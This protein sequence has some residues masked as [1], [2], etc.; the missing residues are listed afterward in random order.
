VS[1]LRL[2]IRNNINN[3]NIT[4][5]DSL[6]MPLDR[7][8]PAFYCCYLLRS[9]VRRSSVYIGSTPH[10]GENSPQTPALR[11]HPYSS[12]P[13]PAQW[14]RQ[15]GSRQDGQTVTAAVGDGLYC[16]RLPESDR[17]PPV[18]VS[19]PSHMTSPLPTQTEEFMSTSR[20]HPF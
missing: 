11:S 7:P 13:R 4:T 1:R 20:M 15:R 17:R 19:G 14:T 5:T 16:D 10:P 9:T 6:A 8:I 3:I 18:R 12:T 2:S